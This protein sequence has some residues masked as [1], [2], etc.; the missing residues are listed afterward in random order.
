VLASAVHRLA[1][2]QAPFRAAI[3]ERLAVSVPAVVA[4]RQL[5]VRPAPHR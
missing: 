3:S 2:A 5:R 4:D 1:W